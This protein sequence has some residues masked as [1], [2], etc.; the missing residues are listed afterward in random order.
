MDHKDNI[1]G[2]RVIRSPVTTLALRLSSPHKF[3]SLKVIRTAD[4]WRVDEWNF[5]R[6]VCPEGFLPAADS[7]NQCD[8]RGT[9]AAKRRRS[10]FLRPKGKPAIRTDGGCCRGGCEGAWPGV[11][12]R[13]AAGRTHAYPRAHRRDADRGRQNSVAC[14]GVDLLP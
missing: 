9:G 2:D 14:P 11:V 10:A 4:T 5:P 7:T 6:P 3:N 8:S 12:R 13:A 1:S